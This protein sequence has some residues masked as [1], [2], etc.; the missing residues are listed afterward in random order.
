M[1]FAKRSVEQT[2]TYARVREAVGSPTRDIAPPPTA[3]PRLTESWFCCAE[4][5]ERQLGALR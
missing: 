1:R 3:R 2:E 4:P 5:T